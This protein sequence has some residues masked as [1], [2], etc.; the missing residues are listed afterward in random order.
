[1]IKPIKKRPSLP[2]PT[3]E[4]V[5]DLVANGACLYVDPRIASFPIP[6]IDL[7]FSAA[8]E[9]IWATIQT[10]FGS[11]IPFFG[12]VRYSSQ[13][14]LEYGSRFLGP[15]GGTVCIIVDVRALTIPRYTCDKLIKKART[16]AAR[17]RASPSYAYSWE[18]HF[19]EGYKK[20]LDNGQ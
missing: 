9:F 16:H 1:M 12:L 8:R 18:K 11:K 17:K 19:A 4:Y 7:K 6:L 15:E 14:R 5:P 2:P 3:T 13:E 10:P 20:C